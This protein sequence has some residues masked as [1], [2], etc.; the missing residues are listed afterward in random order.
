M[1]RDTEG[2]SLRSPELVDVVCDGC[3]SARTVTVAVKEGV[4]WKRRFSIVRCTACQHVYVNPRLRDD[5]V[6]ALY[7]EAYYHGGGFDRTI[8]YDA[9]SRGL[10]EKAERRFNDARLTLELALDGL[11]GRRILEVGCA[12]GWLTQ[13]LRLAGADA[14]GF[15]TSAY[16]QA[17]CARSSIPVIGDFDDLYAQAEA[18]DAIV[19][20]ETIE[21]VF[22]PTE[23]LRSLRNLLKPGGILLI[24]TGN[25]NIEHRV[26]GTPYVMPEGH[27]HYFTPASLRAFLLRSGYEISTVRNHL[28]FGWRAIGRR[29]PGGA[30]SPVFRLLYRACEALAPGIG[31][32]PVGRRPAPATEPV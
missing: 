15:D 5:F 8:D 4:V 14:I 25:W 28:W 32:F 24:G 18:F 17:L 26:R 3:G 2:A 19:S 11:K 27:L 21:H 7:D 29:F 30:K 22:S 20:L 31:P 23:F 10:D 13:M 9:V 1:S 12:G 6:E 16:A